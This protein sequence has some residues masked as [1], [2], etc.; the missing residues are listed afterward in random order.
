M[1]LTSTLEFQLPAGTVGEARGGDLV[2]PTP[3]ARAHQVLDA[4]DRTA[5][6]ADGDGR[7]TGAPL[8]PGRNPAPRSRRALRSASA[9]RAVE[10][11]RPAYAG[12]LYNRTRHPRG[13]FTGSLITNGSRSPPWRKPRPRSR[14]PAPGPAGRRSSGRPYPPGR[15]PPAR[16]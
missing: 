5:S 4:D 1:S 8:T 7:V 16:A 12:P 13:R 6:S 14:R 10:V 9:C 3:V 11:R 2:V 15:A